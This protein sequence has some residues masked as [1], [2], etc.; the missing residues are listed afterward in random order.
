M[1][2]QDSLQSIWF[3]FWLCITIDSS[4]FVDVQQLPLK[5]EFELAIGID[6]Q[7]LYIYHPKSFQFYRI[8]YLYNKIFLFLLLLLFSSCFIGLISSNMSYYLCGYPKRTKDL[9]ISHSCLI[10]PMKI[11][12]F[13]FENQQSSIHVVNF[14]YQR[15]L[16]IY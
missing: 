12:C 9:P 8:L 3:G 1:L 7:N 16:D 13:S 14:H 11:Q 4:P 15:C 6:L 2:F 10:M 5:V